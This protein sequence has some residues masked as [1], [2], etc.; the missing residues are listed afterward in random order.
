VSESGVISVRVD[1]YGEYATTV[2]GLD[3]MIGK[4]LPAS[5]RDL[6]ARVREMYGEDRCQGHIPED[7]GDFSTFGESVYCDGRCRIESTPKTVT[8]C[9]MVLADLHG[10][11]A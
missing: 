10:Y 2:E 4:Y 1:G 3:L 8:E 7:V 6:R 9:L 5:P 11:S